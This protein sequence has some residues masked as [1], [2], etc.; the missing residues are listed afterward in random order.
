M[1]HRIHGAGIYANILGTL[2]GSMLPCIAAPWIL[3]VKYETLWQLNTLRSGK[4]TTF[5]RDIIEKWAM[6][7]DLWPWP[8]I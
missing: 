5:H 7:G 4:T 8:S 2:M 1:S 3:W 6:V